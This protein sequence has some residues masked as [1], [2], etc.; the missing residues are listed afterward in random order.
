LITFGV[1][2]FVT[3]SIRNQRL[4]LFR[5]VETKGGLHIHHLVPGML[6]VLIS[7]YFGLVL[8]GNAATPLLA[9][10]FGIGAALALDE[11]ALWLRLADVYWEP[12]GRESIDAV[13]LAGGV[14]VLYLLGL[15][16][17]P[18]LV[19]AVFRAITSHA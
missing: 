4:R 7:G 12:E 17:W 2:R 5:N 3:Y 6:L 9:I 15:S 16:F 18:D 14:C 8:P 11:F 10:L 1:V 19:E 13:M